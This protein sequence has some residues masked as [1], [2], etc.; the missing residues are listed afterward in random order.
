LTHLRVR[1]A[2]WL[3]L[4]GLVLL[5]SAIAAAALVLGVADAALDLADDVRAAAPW[6]LVAC[7]AVVL[8]VTAVRVARLGQWRLARL[9]ERK[10]ATLGNVLTNAVQL[11]EL[12]TESPVTEALRQAA[13]ERGQAAAHR[14]RTRPVIRASMLRALAAA[15]VVALTWSI[16]VTVFAPALQTV[17][18]RFADPRGD[19]PPFSRLRLAVTPGAVEVI[20]GGQLEVGVA[21]CSRPCFA[22]RTARFS[23]RWPTCARRSS[24]S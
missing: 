4:R 21:H 7:G 17:W 12:K 23:R 3:A 5:G 8:A 18:P 2:G 6:F 15:A 13:V 1:L 9:F 16:V 14:L 11:A 22:R 20:Y 19:H 10:D 24:I